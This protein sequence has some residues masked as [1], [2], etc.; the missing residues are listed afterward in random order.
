MVITKWSESYK[1][2]E[3]HV[4]PLQKSVQY[5]FTINTFTEKYTIL[6]TNKIIISI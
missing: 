4:G 6:S 5:L 1:M 2:E 3:R